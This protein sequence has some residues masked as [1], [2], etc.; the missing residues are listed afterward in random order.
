[1]EVHPLRSAR[2]RSHCSHLPEV[3]R[4]CSAWRFSMPVE[5]GW[6]RDF[7]REPRPEPQEQMA[8]TAGCVPGKGHFPGCPLSCGA[9]QE[10]RK[11]LV[12]L[13]KPHC[14]PSGSPETPRGL[15][16]TVPNPVSSG[17]QP[18]TRLGT[19]RP[20]PSLAAALPG[21]PR[22]ATPLRD[23]SSR[24]PARHGRGV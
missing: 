5:T 24:S 3:L 6:C 1:M 7:S 15:T 13:P 20:A 19:S 16:S 10:R 17:L 22:H 14:G 21:P 12:S 2:A 11:A 4:V 23:G 9:G 18:R 8:A